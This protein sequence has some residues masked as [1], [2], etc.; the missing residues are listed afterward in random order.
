M[1]QHIN[2][3]G[4]GSRR[5]IPRSAWSLCLP[6][7]AGLVLPLGLWGLR[8]FAVARTVQEQAQV[9]QQLQQAR[10]QLAMAANR[11]GSRVAESV[12]SLRARARAAQLL[13]IRLAELGSSAGYSRYFDALASLSEPQIWLTSIEIGRGDRSLNLHGQALDSSRVISYSKRVNARLTDFGL[14]LEGLE[15][16]AVTAAQ[17][18]AAGPQDLVSFKLY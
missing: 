15:I 17:P 3:L 4:R 16:G 1:T 13:R 10:Q 5:R 8:G 6:L 18:G 9:Q 12:D 14:V 2:L 11:P 7:V